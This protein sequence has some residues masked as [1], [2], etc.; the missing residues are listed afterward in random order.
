VLRHKNIVLNIIEFKVVVTIRHSRVEP[1]PVKM[2]GNPDVF[3]LDSR[4]PGCVAIKKN[5]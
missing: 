3:E 1:A 4:L 2:G 5:F